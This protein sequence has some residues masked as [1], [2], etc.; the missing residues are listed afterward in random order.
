M[1]TDLGLSLIKDDD[2]YLYLEKD[3][4]VDLIFP[5]SFGSS[6]KK[7]IEILKR[8]VNDEPAIL[9]EIEAD[10]YQHNG[11]DVELLI[12]QYNLLSY[13]QQV[14]ADDPT[15][16]ITFYPMRK[17]EIKDPL[18]FTIGDKEYT[19]NTY[20]SRFLFLPKT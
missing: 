1:Y 4:Q 17:G 3:E 15:A 12:K 18:K 13:Q 14:D 5:Y 10:T 2:Q 6:E 20:K 11:D 7:S 9:A 16:I 8:Y 19:L